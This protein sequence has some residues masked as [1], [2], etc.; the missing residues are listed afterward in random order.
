MPFISSVR[1]QYGPQGKKNTKWRRYSFSSHT[2]TP[3]GATGRFGPTLSQVQS[4]YSSASWINGPGNMAMDNQGIQLWSVPSAGVYRI[5]AA[6]GK[7]G[8]GNGN[9]GQG[10]IMRGDFSLQNGQ[11]LRILVGQQGANGNHASGQVNGGGGGASAVSVVGGSLLIVAGGGA[12]ITNNSN[13]SNSNRN[14]RTG[15]NS[16]N[17]GSYGRSTYFFQQQS[18]G[19]SWDGGGGGSWGANGDQYANQRDAQGRDIS[20]TNPIGGSGSWDGQATIPGDGGFGGGGG[21]GI[22]SGAGGGGGGYLGGNAMYS[23]SS[24]YVDGNNGT[25]GGSYNNG[26]SQSNDIGNNGTGYVIIQKLS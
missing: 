19:S 22:N 2:F 16:T 26:S 14:A 25:G 11:T 7:G 21:S 12:G 17:S 3:A 4:S 5:T 10:A 6:G 9:G 23:Y 20:G 18:A 8:G 1:S 13:E 24:T 15:N